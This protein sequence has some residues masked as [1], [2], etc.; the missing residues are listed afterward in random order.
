MARR[1]EEPRLGDVGL[2]GVGLGAGERGIEPRQ[3]LGALVNAALEVLVGA[4]QRLGGLDAG[5]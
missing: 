1:G 3:F 2:V 4:F 5:R